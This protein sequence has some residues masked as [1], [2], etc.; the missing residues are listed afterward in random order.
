MFIPNI[1]FMGAA[2]YDIGIYRGTS[3]KDSENIVT[4][5]W[6]LSHTITNIEIQ[7]VSS[8][9][10]QQ[11]EGIGNTIEYEAF[12]QGTSADI[13][14]GDRIKDPLAASTPSEANMEAFNVQKWPAVDG[15]PA[16]V[17]FLV[18]KIREV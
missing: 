3:S 13:L 9:I 16:Y 18:R 5:A 12:I 14:N 1:P 15:L 10:R 8:N 6:S 17:N 11:F 7:P 4:K 2:K